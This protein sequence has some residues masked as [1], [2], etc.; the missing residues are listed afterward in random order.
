VTF[1]DS[2]SHILQGFSNDIFHS[3]A[4]IDKISTD[5]VHRTV[6]MHYL[7]EIQQVEVVKE[8]DGIAVFH[9]SLQHMDSYDLVHI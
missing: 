9:P 3:F 1:K 6:P 7:S 8:F 4:A 5:V 2:R